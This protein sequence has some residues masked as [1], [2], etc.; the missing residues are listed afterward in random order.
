M[1]RPAQLDVHGPTRPAA[2]P[3]EKLDSTAVSQ[4]AIFVASIA[5]LE[6]LKAT[7]GAVSSAGLHCRLPACMPA[8]SLVPRPTD[9]GPTGAATAGEGLNLPRPLQPSGSQP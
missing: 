3:K 6:K 2:G 7:E 5:A 1:P 9:C 4:P 8:C